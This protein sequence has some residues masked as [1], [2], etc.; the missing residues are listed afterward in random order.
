MLDVN[1]K[2]KKN[3]KTLTDSVSLLNTLL[4]GTTLPNR[5]LWHAIHL[6][7]MIQLGKLHWENGSFI[8]ELPRVNNMYVKH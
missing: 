7:A 1:R 8:H 6:K 2:E 3:K 4:K 5:E